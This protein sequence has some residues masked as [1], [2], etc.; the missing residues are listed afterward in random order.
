MYIPRYLH[1]EEATSPPASTQHPAPIFSPMYLL[2]LAVSLQYYFSA[3]GVQSS[4]PTKSRLNFCGCR[5][6]RY[7]LTSDIHLVQQ[8]HDLCSAARQRRRIFCPASVPSLLWVCHCVKPHCIVQRY[9]SSNFTG[10]MHSLKVTSK[11]CTL[12]VPSELQIDAERVVPRHPNSKS[13]KM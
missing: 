3:L 12:T 7:S 9:S 2:V 6:Y 5:L 13:G 11:W 10:C 4:D 1:S 8:M